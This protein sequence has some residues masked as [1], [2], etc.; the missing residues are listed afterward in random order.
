[1]LLDIYEKGILN[2]RV[3]VELSKHMKKEMSKFRYSIHSWLLLYGYIVW[4]ERMSKRY[5]SKKAVY[6][7][8]NKI[9]KCIYVTLWSVGRFIKIHKRLRTKRMEIIMKSIIRTKLQLI[10]LKYRIHSKRSI[11]KFIHNVETNKEFIVLL[12]KLARAFLVL[13]RWLTRI[14]I[15]KRLKF[16]AINRN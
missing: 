6:K 9:L 5:I 16:V 13:K 1:M 11:A 4:L 15:K 3:K 14:I 7:R 12:N 2:K 8:T 10:K